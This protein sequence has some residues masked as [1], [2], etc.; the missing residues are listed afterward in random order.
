MEDRFKFIDD[1]SI[2]EIVNL[3]TVGLTSYNLKQHI[4][5]D[6]PPH[7]QYIPAEN[8][9]SQ[10]WLNEVNEWTESQKMLVNVKK[11]KTMI[12]NYT[13]NSQ[14]TTRLKINNVQID[15]ID[16]TRLRGTIIQNDLS[17]DFN[18]ASLI[19]KADGRMELLRRVAGFGTPT[20]DLKIIYFLFVI[21]ILEQSATV[22]HSSLTQDNANDL[23][24]VRKSALRIILGTKYKSYIEGLA[25]LGI[26]TLA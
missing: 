4:P 14:F 21:S 3:L 18:T 6:I 23:G 11:T 25:Q 2:L 8:L 22:W 13:E 1:L 5:S 26:E 16:S 15:V 17:W 20:E 9:Q 19:K 7:N 24:R 10:D 12:Y